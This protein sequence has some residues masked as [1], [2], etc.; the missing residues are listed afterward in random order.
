MGNEASNLVS[1]SL[2]RDNG[3]FT[4]NSLVGVEIESQT[5]VVL[6]DNDSGGLLNSLCTD[7][8][9]SQE[10]KFEQKQKLRI[11]NQNIRLKG[12]QIYCLFDGSLNEIKWKI[13]K[14]IIKKFCRDS[15]FCYFNII[16]DVVR[17]QRNCFGWI[18]GLSRGVT[19][20]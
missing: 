9:N 11:Y 16:F 1:H 12:K 6:L 4:C 19:N 17:R 13:I 2:W 14:Q 10:I 3:D 18:D 15:P 5:R 8:L 20:R 7:T